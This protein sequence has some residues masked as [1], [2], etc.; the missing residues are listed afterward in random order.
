M[1]LKNNFILTSEI[2]NSVYPQVIFYLGLMI[3]NF[4]CSPAVYRQTA[5]ECG[6]YKM[7]SRTVATPFVN[8]IPFSYGYG[9]VFIF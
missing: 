7:A 1:S 6:R 5:W 4:E 8:G 2:L 3:K 9:Y